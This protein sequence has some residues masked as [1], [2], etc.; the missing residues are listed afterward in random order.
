[1]LLAT[2]RVK[3]TSRDGTQYEVRALLGQGSEVSFI[4]E[5]LAQRVNHPRTREFLPIHGIGGQRS[6]VCRGRVT[7]NIASRSN[8]CFSLSLNAYILSKLT[9]YV[10]PVRVLTASWSH[11]NGLPLADPGFADST[12]I[13]LVLGAEVYGAILEE[14]LRKGDVGSPIVQKTTLGWILSGSV[15]SQADDSPIFANGLQCSIDHEL[16]DLL[17]RFWLQEET[18]SSQ[19]S[20]VSEED[21]Q[22]EQ[23]FTATHFRTPDGR[24]VV[25]LPVKNLPEE[26]GHS[27]KPAQLALWRQ[28]KRFTAN[29]TLKAAYSKFL[30][31]YEELGHMQ[32]ISPSSPQPRR[33]F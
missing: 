28:E 12:P 22:C 4:S 2:A 15:A 5:S 21:A 3:I 31:E 33:V 25:R 13:D 26:L 17:Q 1:M 14:G 16:S 27:R 9:S 29:Q 8:S 7:V 24:Y 19:R 11:L 23:H 20:L 30:A 32:L 18:A 6:T 10:P